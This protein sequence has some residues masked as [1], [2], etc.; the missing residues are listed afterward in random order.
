MSLNSSIPVRFDRAVKDRL[1]R[2]SDNTGVP[3]AQLVRIATEQYLEQIEKSRSVVIPLALRE[4][5]AKRKGET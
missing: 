1:Q 3:P 2:V 5:P 4:S